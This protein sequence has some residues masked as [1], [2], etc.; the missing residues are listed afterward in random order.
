MSGTVWPWCVPSACEKGGPGGGHISVLL[1]EPPGSPL[2]SLQA[3]DLLRG[4]V[5][6]M[7]GSVH[8]MDTVT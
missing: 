2:G 6:H 4:S 7:I 5:L 8:T 3:S 1:A